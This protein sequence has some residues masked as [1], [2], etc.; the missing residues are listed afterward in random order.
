MQSDVGSTVTDMF[1]LDAVSNINLKLG[2]DQQSGYTVAN[3]IRQHCGKWLAEIGRP[4]Y[5]FYRGAKLADPVDTAKVLPIPKNRP[6]RDSTPIQNAAFIAMIKAA[7]G[8]ANRFNSAFVTSKFSSATEY[9][10]VYV[11]MPIGDFHYT[12]STEWA[13]WTRDL[14]SQDIIRWL[15]PEIRQRFKA[16]E[17]S[18]DEYSIKMLPD[19]LERMRIVSNPDSFVREVDSVIV[20]DKGLPNAR[21]ARHEVM[22]SAEMGLYIDHTFYSKL[23]EPFLEYPNLK[24]NLP[25]VPKSKAMGIV[26][27]LTQPD[28]VQ[29][30]L[31]KDAD[32]LKAFGQAINDGTQQKLYTGKT[33][34]GM[35]FIDSVFRKECTP[36]AKD[37]LFY[38]LHQIN[39]KEW[40]ESF[41]ITPERYAKK[42]IA[43]EGT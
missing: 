36:L 22:V 8:V 3:F 32:H 18:Y 24:P 15:K 27:D 11:F 13:D 19:P 4:N 31:I 17:G 23:V 30:L 16:P 10:D 21:L 33:N 37:I 7:G 34:Y 20:A 9:G 35:E 5:V 14:K 12:W 43:K 29:T 2:Q 28:Y 6:P 38:P 25:A 1:Y 41:D 42:G 39:R 40:R 26:L